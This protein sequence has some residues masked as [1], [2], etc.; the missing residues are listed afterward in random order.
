MTEQLDALVD[1]EVRRGPRLVR[2]L[3]IRCPV[4][5]TSADTG[6]ELHAFAELRRRSQLLVDCLECGQD[7]EWTVDDAFVE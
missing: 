7:H 5:G 2:R 6:F 3:L 4:T 1:A